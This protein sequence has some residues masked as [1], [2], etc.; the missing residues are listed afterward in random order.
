M[1]ILMTRLT[2][3]RSTD[4][5]LNLSSVIMFKRLHRSN[6]V[7]S[8]TSPIFSFCVDIRALRFEEETEQGGDGDA[9]EAV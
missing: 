3:E 2:T 5:G 9:E 8:R 6:K 7:I 1:S 4:S